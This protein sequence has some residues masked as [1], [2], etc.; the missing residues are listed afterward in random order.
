MMPWRTLRSNPCSRIQ[1]QPHPFGRDQ[2]IAFFTLVPWAT[3]NK[4]RCDGE[5]Q[6]LLAGSRNAPRNLMAGVR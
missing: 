4:Q 3:D 5:L 6:Q 1:F 2:M